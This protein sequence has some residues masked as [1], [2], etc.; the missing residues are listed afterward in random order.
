M[1]KFLI[2]RFSSIGDIIQCMQVVSGIYDKYPDATIHWITRKDMSMVLT[3]DKRI[4]KIWEFDKKSG[5]KGL[6]ALAMQLRKEKYDYIYDAHS[7]IRSNI[8]KLVLS[9]I[10][11]AKPRIALRSKERLKRVLLFRFGINKFDKPFKSARSF[12]KPL[13]KWGIKNFPEDYSAWDFPETFAPKFDKLMQS[14]TVTLIPSTNWVMKCWPVAHWQELVRLLP[15]Y[16]FV[17][18]GGPQDTF[19]E[20]IRAVAPDRVVNLAGATSLWESCYL[21][22]ASKF[23]ISGDTG[24]M[25]A[26]DL[27]RTP[28]LAIMGPSAFGYPSGDSVEVMEVDL[29]C[30]PCS[31]DGSGKCKQKVYQQCMV[32]VTSQRIAQRVQ[33][34][35]SFE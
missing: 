30:R 33:E 6:L 21:V 35:L 15:D 11:F 13:Y 32:D 12:Q 29:P 14:N 2:I 19:C 1:P 31:K 5:F 26:A 10:P 8:L 24:F 16:N 4:D 7:N 20:T 3:M 9:P 22:K 25:H 34:R 28:A 18:L 23:V 27:F 17:I